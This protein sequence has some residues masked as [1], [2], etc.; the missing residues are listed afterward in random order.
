MESNQYKYC[1]VIREW[2]IK[3]ID[4]QMR[5]GIEWSPKRDEVK[6]KLHLWS[7]HLCIL[8]TIP[9]KARLNTSCQQFTDLSVPEVT[10]NYLDWFRSIDNAK[11][12]AI[13]Y[14]V[15]G[16]LHLK[17]MNLPHHYILN[18]DWV[19][20]IKLNGSKLQIVLNPVI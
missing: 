19:R 3:R 18:D 9:I 20:T 14:Y 15:G 8:G 16:T 2:K 5:C 17:R 7:T 1:V 6:Q 11:M 10:E 4:K 12:N 13:N